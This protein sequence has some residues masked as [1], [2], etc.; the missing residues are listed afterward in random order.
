L[1]PAALAGFLP[2]VA[3][4]RYSARF[5]A[6]RVLMGGP[7]AGVIGF[8]LLAALHN[9]PWQVI[10]AGVLA[11]AY[12]SL[13]YGALPALVV[14]E[15]DVDETGVA[16]SMNAIARTIGSSIAAAIVAVLLGRSQQGHIPESSFTVIFALGAITAGAAM[17]L[18]AVTR[19]RL[20]LA[21]ADDVTESRAM[22]HEWG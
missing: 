2:G 9:E 6:R 10:M 8:V 13:A 1:G 15:V 17:L 21:S 12:I 18:I 20:R 7:A 4:G 3:C 14:R 11:N 22:N 5:G 19:P 16:T